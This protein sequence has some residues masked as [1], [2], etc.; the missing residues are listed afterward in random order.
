MR[1]R[2]RH[3]PMALLTTAALAA[4]FATTTPIHAAAGTRPA[5]TITGLSL[6]HI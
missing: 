5:C 1:T 3:L 2:P 4:A 6:I